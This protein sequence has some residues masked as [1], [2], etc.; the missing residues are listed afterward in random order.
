MDTNK[1]KGHD[2]ADSA[3]A[4]PLNL[5]GDMGETLSH[6]N[7]ESN[8]KAFAD[9]MDETGNHDTNDKKKLNPTGENDDNI[10]GVTQTGPSET[11]DSD[12]TQVRPETPPLSPAVLKEENRSSSPWASENQLKQFRASSVQVADDYL[13]KHNSR[14][15]AVLHRVRRSRKTCKQDRDGS[16]DI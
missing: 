5:A 16:E 7:A 6:G 8:E 13:K 14:T 3:E 4:K 9:N 10:T 2:N 12:N 1:A 15:S 11:I